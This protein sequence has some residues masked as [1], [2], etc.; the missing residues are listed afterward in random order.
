MRLPLFI[1]VLVAGVA[2][3]VPADEARRR[4]GSVAPDIPYSEGGDQHK[5]DLYLPV[6]KDFT[7]VV[8]TYGGGW[9]AGSRKS[10]APIGDRLQR[11]GFGCALLSHRL[12]PKDKF[13][14]QAQDVAAAFAWVEK[15]IRG[16]GGDPQRV[17]LM[18]HSS[19]A[20]LSLLLATD[21]KYLAEHK[22]SPRDIAAVVGLSTPVDLEPR[23]D[24]RGFGDALM[25]GRG[26]DVF[27]RDVA[28]LKAASPIQHVSKDLP[29]TLLVVGEKDFPM[30]EGDARRFAEKAKKAGRE[31]TTFVGPGCDHMGV[32]RSL[33]DD[34]SAIAI[35]VKAF[36]KKVGGE[37]K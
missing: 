3:S 27:S 20:H 8:F 23:A 5:L 16:K 37:A 17:V 25:G 4:G 13:P 29:P 31:V 26:A 34:R 36:L 21:P 10:V 15:N 30:L 1:I 6:Q 7:T 18:G 22:L 35:Q 33:L 28:V 24:K 19:G 2:G 32:V 11:L 14:A 9:H 12:G